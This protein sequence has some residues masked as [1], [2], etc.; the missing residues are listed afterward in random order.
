MHKVNSQ[1]TLFAAPAEYIHRRDGT[2]PQFAFKRKLHV[3]VAHLKDQCLRMGHHVQ[4]NDLGWSK[5][6]VTEHY[7]YASGSFLAL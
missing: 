2:L 4:T 7:G 5:A 1:F 3:M 6:C